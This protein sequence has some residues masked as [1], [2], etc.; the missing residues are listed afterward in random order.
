MSDHHTPEFHHSL[1]GLNPGELPARWNCVK[2]HRQGTTGEFHEWI[3]S[4][5]STGQDVLDRVEDTD[6]S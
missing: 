3:C 1:R 4:S 5:P 6:Q 2:C